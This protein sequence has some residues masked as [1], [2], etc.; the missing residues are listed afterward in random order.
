LFGGL[1]DSPLAKLNIGAKKF[2]YNGNQLSPLPFTTPQ[3]GQHWGTCSTT[4]PLS[5]Q[6]T[7]IN[8]LEKFMDA[9]AEIGAHKVESILAP[10]MRVFALVKLEGA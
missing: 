5:V 3:F 10:R 9:M 8:N 7:K 1:S 4:S 6:S 2:E